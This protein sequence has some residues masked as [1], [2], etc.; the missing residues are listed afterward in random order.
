MT[1]TIVFSLVC[2]L[3]YTGISVWYFLHLVGQKYRKQKWYDYPMLTPAI[4]II[5][6]YVWVDRLIK[7]SNHERTPK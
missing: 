2:I 6:M 5:N 7:R 1:G 3:L 4:V